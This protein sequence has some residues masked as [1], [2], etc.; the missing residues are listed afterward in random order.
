[1]DTLLQIE[2]NEIAEIYLAKR[3]NRI[4]IFNILK[5]LKFKDPV[6]YKNL[7]YRKV[8]TEFKK[9]FPLYKNNRKNT[10]C[11][12]ISEIQAKKNRLNS[13]FRLMPFTQINIK[14]YGFSN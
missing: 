9:L 14:S 6:S 7:S 11:F 8:K 12:K 1:M 13:K 3:L 5:H 10:Y 4:S 2:I